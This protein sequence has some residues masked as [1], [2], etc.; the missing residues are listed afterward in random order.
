MQNL[1]GLSRPARLGSAQRGC[2]RLGSAWPSSAQL[3]SARA[4]AQSRA[5]LGSSSGPLGLG[6]GSAH[7]CSAT[8]LKDDALSIREEC[9]SKTSLLIHFE[10]KWHLLLSITQKDFL[11][12]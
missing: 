8:V 11:K 9:D 7:A 4:R 1:L 2:A 6:L 10:R 12:E 5:Q 3:G